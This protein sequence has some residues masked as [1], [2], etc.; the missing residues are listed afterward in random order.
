[1]ASIWGA[2]E[3]PS[4]EA[5]EPVGAEKK[6]YS[7]TKK[8]KVGI[9]STAKVTE[10]TDYYQTV[11]T[12]GE[13][14]KLFL[15]NMDDQPMGSPIVIPR[16]ELS[17]NYTHRPEYLERKKAGKAA[18]VE[19]HVRA[20]DDHFRK[21]EYFSAEFE[22]GKALSLNENHLR[23]N[24]GKGKTLF[25]AGEKEEAKKIFSRLSKIDALYE[26]ENKH[27]FNEVGIELRQKGMLAEAIMNYRKAISIDP[28]DE[29]LYFNLARACFEQG[30]PQEA[31]NHLAAALRLK[32]DF[33]EAKEFLAVISA[34]I[35]QACNAIPS[36]QPL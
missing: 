4:R 7:Q 26:K 35:P 2:S 19:G 25:A 13:E 31:A 27:I 24:L 3:H 6:V 17:K 30:E 34:A 28:E 5:G 11:E 14:V 8:I 22:Y 20:G 21:K 16:D 36:A 12:E 18:K 29:V 15:L 10:I 9:G 1:L 32:P 33:A 23:A